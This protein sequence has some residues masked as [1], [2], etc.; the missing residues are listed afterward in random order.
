MSVPPDLAIR[1]E[2]AGA[3]LAHYIRAKHPG[4]PTLCGRGIPDAAEAPSGRAAGWCPLCLTYAMRL[5]LG[6]T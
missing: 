5:R 2:A 1:I 4:S 6:V 3:G